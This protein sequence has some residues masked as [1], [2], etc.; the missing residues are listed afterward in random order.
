MF[1][2]MRGTGDWVTDQRPM[3][4]RQQILYLYP[5]GHAPLTAMLSMMGS[6]KVDDPQFHWWTQ[7]QTSVGGTVAGVYTVPDL[8]TAYTS[9]GVAG[10]TIYIPRKKSSALS[11]LFQRGNILNDILRIIITATTSIL[12]F[13][14]IQ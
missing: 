11:D 7:E 4:W 5:N 1:L 3:N 2:G 13:N 6:K 12:I 14:L 8:S 10:D 9:G